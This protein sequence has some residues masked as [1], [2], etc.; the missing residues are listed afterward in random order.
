MHLYFK[1]LI[2]RVRIK[3]LLNR[4]Q[5]DKDMHKTVTI[6]TV[7]CM[8]LSF[9][10]LYNKALILT[11]VIKNFSSSGHHSPVSSVSCQN[12]YKLSK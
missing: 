12:K 4:S 11:G 6:H 5:N 1:I 8:S 2:T 7:L 9:W 10:L 3:A